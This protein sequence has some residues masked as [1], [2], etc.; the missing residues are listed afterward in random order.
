M[1]GKPR[2]EESPVVDIQKVNGTGLDVQLVCEG[3]GVPGY[4]VGQSQQLH[5]IC[6]LP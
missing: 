1:L 5:L 4:P 2:A 6:F 3:R